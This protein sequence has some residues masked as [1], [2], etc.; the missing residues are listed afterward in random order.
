MLQMHGHCPILEATRAV[1]TLLVAVC[2]G[3]QVLGGQGL[4]PGLL[5]PLLRR[6]AWPR[7]PASTPLVTL[8]LRDEEHSEHPEPEPGARAHASAAV[9]VSRSRGAEVPGG[10]SGLPDK[11]GR[12]E[13]PAQPAR[14]K[15]TDS[16]GAKEGAGAS[17]RKLDIIPA[18]RGRLPRSLWRPQKR[19]HQSQWQL[20]KQLL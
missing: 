9:E 17:S 3:T 1:S 14:P 16:G 13:G 18:T 2:D 6:G 12:R 15:R 4:R 19:E 11:P 8:G 20:R 7:S 10:I 5:A